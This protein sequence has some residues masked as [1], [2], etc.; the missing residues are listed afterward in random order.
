MYMRSALA[1]LAFLAVA[2]PAAALEP[3]ELAGAWVTVWSNGPELPVDGGGPLAI[4]VENADTLDGHQP[5]AGQ[6]GVMN[7]EVSTGENGALIWA[8]QWVSVWPRDVT[9]GTFRFVFTDA[10]TFTGVWSTDDGEV[11]DA[12]WNG[13][14]VPG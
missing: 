13:R 1:A 7:G 9:R 8:G 5:A 11:K 6:D 14:R 2:T 4:A 3:A 12:I 10:D